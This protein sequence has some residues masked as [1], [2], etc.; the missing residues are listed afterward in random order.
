M[1][2]SQGKWFSMKPELLVRTER[3]N[4]PEKLH[5]GFVSVID[6]NF[7]YILKTGDDE[8]TPF[9]FRSGAKPLQASVVI[10]SGTHE[11]F[12][13]DNKEIATFCASH[14]GMPVHTEKVK[15]ILRKIGL[16][17]ENLQCGPHMPLDTG[18]KEELIRQKKHATALHNN[19]SGKHAGMLAVCVKNNWDVPSY[20]NVNHP[21]QK[22]IMQNIKDLCQLKDIPVT[23]L[24]GC[25]A[26]VPILPHYNMGIGFLNLFLNPK[27]EQI[28]LAMAQ[29]P[30]ITGG[31]GRID[32]EIIASSKGKLIAKIAAEG[33]CIVV[34]TRLK[35]AL[36]V[37]IIDADF[38]ARSIAV[39]DSLK[40]L[41]WL[42]EKEIQASEN[43][44]FLAKKQ[45][46]NWKN[47]IVGEIKVFIQ[48]E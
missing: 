38:K 43:L 16:T 48:P 12:G 10:D 28:K 26:P 36:I 39:I 4:F 35:Q 3:G 31:I 19:C 32:S 11:Y 15:S 25:S 30:Y 9:P 44:S 5:Y 47:K 27:Y 1:N 2:F 21:V 40:K 29:N 13:F 42:S 46:T 33:V 37:K 45:I 24:D 41:G 7:N 18:E 8:N 23:A 6:E 22:L 34:N 14:A 17:P 20:L